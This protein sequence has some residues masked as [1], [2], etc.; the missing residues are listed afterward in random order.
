MGGT[1]RATTSPASTATALVR[2]SARAAP[3]KTA[4]REPP[5]AS[6]MVAN[7]VLSP[8][9]ARKTAAKVEA[10][11]F[12]SMRASRAEA[13]DTRAAGGAEQRA[14]GPHRRG[15][16]GRSPRKRAKAV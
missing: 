13:H 3:T 12:Q 14:G 5:A 1:T 2:T 15:G 10:R 4:Q 7:C 11:S 16:R 9:S 8:I 6:D